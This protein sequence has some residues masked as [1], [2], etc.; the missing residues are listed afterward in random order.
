MTIKAESYCL[1]LDTS[2]RAV[3]P[4]FMAGVCHEV[5]VDERWIVRIR[6]E[7]QRRRLPFMRLRQQHFERNR[8]SPILYG[9]NYWKVQAFS[10]RF[11]KPLKKSSRRMNSSFHQWS[12]GNR[13]SI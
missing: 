8:Q 13:Y 5:F 10:N 11:G 3:Q 6:M 7:Y 1:G 9:L 12:S 4:L 2:M